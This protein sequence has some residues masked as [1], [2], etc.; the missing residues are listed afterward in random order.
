MPC[1]F[2]VHVCLVSAQPTPNLLPVL[3][4]RYAPRKKRV[5]LLVT[6]E[7][8]GAADNLGAVYTK[9]GLTAEK[10]D[11]ENPYDFT[12]IWE[13]L[14]QCL[15]AE[16]NKN[17][18]LNVTGGTKIMTLAAQSV[19]A[20]A[21]RPMFYVKES[22]NS[23]IIMPNSDAGGRVQTAR[24]D[25]SPD[26]ADYLLAHGY[27]TLPAP[28]ASGRE[29]M[30]AP[31]FAEKLI[32]SPGRYEAGLSRL[33]RY[34]MRD[35]RKQ[36]RFSV[37]GQRD[38]EVMRAM[39]K[40]CED[41]GLASA[42]DNG[43][44]EFA[45]ENAHAYVCGGWLEYYVYGV[46]AKIGGEKIRAKARNLIIKSKGGENELDVAF[47]AKNRLHILECKTARLEREK[48]AEALYKLQTLTNLTGLKT[49]AMF[50]SY[51]SLDKPGIS[52]RG[53]GPHKKRAAAFGITVVERHELRNLKAHLEKWIA[54]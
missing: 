53:A 25:S 30:S 34:A 23:L 41:C 2:D 19:F 7:M 4:G 54:E 29:C 46:V 8:R 1:D 39:L 43:R 33:N 14:Y 3:D 50:I 15:A 40:L 37:D 5:I 49:K 45:D 47:L 22:D 44:V 18:A 35:N 28:A 26:L 36:L 51:R 13:S 11:I 10:L 20:A 27:K 32:N 9:H 38:K 21:K 16:E 17:I 52:G 31:G 48:G 42:D 6:P 24:L 12:E